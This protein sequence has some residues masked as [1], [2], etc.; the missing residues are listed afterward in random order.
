MPATRLTSDDEGDCPPLHDPDFPEQLLRDYELAEALRISG[1]A[2]PAWHAHIEDVF[3]YAHR[4]LRKWAEE[5]TLLDHMHG[6]TTIAK[7]NRDRLP[8]QRQLSVSEVDDLVAHLM[9]TAIPVYRLRLMDGSW[10]PDRGRSLRSYC[11]QQLKFQ[12]ARRYWSWAA[13]REAESAR[14]EAELLPTDRVQPALHGDVNAWA[15][16]MDAVVLVMS[17]TEEIAAAARGDE[18]TL[19]IVRMNA[20]G[21]LDREIAVA[22]NVT[23]KTVELRLRRFRER[24]AAHRR[25]VA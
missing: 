2:G 19:K 16:P 15:Q 20:Q 11:L 6:D 3:G 21:H 24:A 25:E 9:V 5:G 10:R 7:R 14:P 8:T 18:L 4:A 1:C 23:A 17:I 22:M 13:E 12:L